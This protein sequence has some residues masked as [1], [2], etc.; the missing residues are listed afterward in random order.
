MLPIYN[1]PDWETLRPGWL[2][3][4]AVLDTLIQENA[5]VPIAAINTVAVSFPAQAAVLMGRHPLSESR[6]TLE[7]WAR[8][9]GNTGERAQRALARVA[10]MMLAKDPG[11]SAGFWYGDAF[12][13]LG[14]VGSVVAASQVKLQITINS[15]GKAPS[16]R[17]GA[18]CGDSA[19]LKP[20]PGWPPVYSY[21]LLQQKPV[22][23]MLSVVELNGDEILAWRNE[24][25]GAAHT[26]CH[27]SGWLDSD[28][29]F[30]E[31]ITYWL[32]V[33][34]TGMTWWPVQ[35]FGI[36]WTSKAAY[37]QR[38]GEIVESEREKLRATVAALQQRGFLTA[39]DAA[40]V[41]P[42]IVVSVE[43]ELKPC[44]LK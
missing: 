8:G 26:G 15:D 35:N 19:A 20:S 29:I 2:A 3:T 44:P 36:K 31:L 7:Q 39:D 27:G 24:S 22:P 5:N 14:L 23:G 30:H 25:N 40:T 42:K 34:V 32:G 4:S 10:L 28:Y 41:T 13:P 21:E 6:P 18:A 38:L 37:Q 33:K 11:P 12:T 43:C 1:P 17:G 9:A 16:L